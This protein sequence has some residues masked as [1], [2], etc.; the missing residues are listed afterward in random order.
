MRVFSVNLFRFEQL[1]MRMANRGE[2]RLVLEFLSEAMARQTEIRDYIS[3]ETVMAPRAGRWDS[4]PPLSE[5]D[6]LLP[7]KRG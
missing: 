2:W 5:R 3:G 7:W 4:W 1:L 6:R